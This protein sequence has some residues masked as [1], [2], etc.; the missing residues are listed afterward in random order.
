MENKKDLYKIIKIGGMII[1]IPLMLLLGPLAGFFLGDFLSQ[2]FGW[3]RNLV[4]VFMILGFFS[5][6]LETLRIVRKV[7]AMEKN[8]DSVL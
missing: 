4:L 1:F 5:S 2:K 7:S 3:S 6:V 8:K